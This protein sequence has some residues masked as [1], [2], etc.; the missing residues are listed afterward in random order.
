VVVSQTGL[1][2]FSHRVLFAIFDL[3]GEFRDRKCFRNQ[4][5][6]GDYWI[7]DVGPNYDMPWSANLI[8]GLLVSE[9]L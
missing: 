1:P 2:L 6:Y 5:F 4:P 8:V 9:R 7:L 3:R